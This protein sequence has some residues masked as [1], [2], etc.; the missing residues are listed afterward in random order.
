MKFDPTDPENIHELNAFKAQYGVGNTVR[1]LGGYEGRLNNADDRI[2]LLRPGTPPADEPNYIP[3]FQEDE[4]LFDDRAPWPIGADGTGSSLQRKT[5]GAFG[6]D[7]TSW[8]S[9][10]PSPGRHLT[11]HSGRLPGRRPRECDRH[12]PA[13]RPTASPTPDLSYDLTNDGKVNAADRD[14]LV[15]GVIG[16]TYGDANLD[17]IFDSADFVQAFQSGEYEDAA[18]VNS[19]WE[20]GDWNGDGEFNSNDFILAFTFGGYEVAGRRRSGNWRLSR[21]WSARRWRR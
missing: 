10:S 13:V 3:R 9:G 5:A 1:M 7:A 14:Q 11:E 18:S 19:G 15:V 2:T 17:L 8:F 12:Q 20:E 16:T 4:V 21:S 6:N